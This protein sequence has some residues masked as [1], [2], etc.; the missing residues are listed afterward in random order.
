[1]ENRFDQLP[2]LGILDGRIDGGLG[3]NWSAA[4]RSGSAGD[5]VGGVAD[6]V[7]RLAEDVLGAVEQVGRET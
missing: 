2:T 4:A 5:G 3:R 1:M 6:V 7:Q